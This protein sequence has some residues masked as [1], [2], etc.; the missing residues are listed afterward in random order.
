MEAWISSGLPQEQGL[1]LQQATADPCL[2]RRHSNNK[3]QVWL[4]L[5]RASG[6][7]CIKRFVW[8]LQESV[9]PVLCNSDSSMV[10]LMETSFKGAYATPGSAV[11]RAPPPVTGYC[12]PRPPQKTLKHSK[13]GLAQSLWVLLVHT[14]LCLS[15]LS[16]LL[17]MRFDSKQNFASPAVLLG[18]SFVLGHG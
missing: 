14:K 17:H 15:P 4:S 16:I 12:C 13:A 11:P 5:F 8:A 7:K 10:G 18:L 1:F 6:S 3:R 9:S 2:H